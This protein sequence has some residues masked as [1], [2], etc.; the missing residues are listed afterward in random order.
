VIVSTHSP[1]L[2]DS[3]DVDADSILAVQMGE[4]G[5]TQIGALDEAGRSV[6]RDRLYSP[7]ELMRINHLKPR[8]ENFDSL[9]LSDRVDV[10][11]SPDDQ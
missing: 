3:D 10:E 11:L 5:A 2:L 9:K 8:R 6:L 7:G 4:D 1:D